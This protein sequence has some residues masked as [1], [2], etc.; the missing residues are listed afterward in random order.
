MALVGDLISLFGVFL[1]VGAVYLAIG[2]PGVI[3]VV[4]VAFVYLGRSLYKRA[5]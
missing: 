2:W 4:G 3:G 5:N 1:V